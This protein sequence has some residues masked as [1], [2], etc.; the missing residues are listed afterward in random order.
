VKKGLKEVV[1]IIDRSMA[2][3]G[4]EDVEAWEL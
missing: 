3:C 4:L 2:M 1:F